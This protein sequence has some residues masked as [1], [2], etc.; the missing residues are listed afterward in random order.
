MRFIWADGT[1][2]ELPMGACVRGIILKGQRPIDVTFSLKDVQTL[3]NTDPVSI[4]S[5]VH[6]IAMA[7]KRVP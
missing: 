7:L 1:K 6:N 5:Y 4:E 3:I 2:Q